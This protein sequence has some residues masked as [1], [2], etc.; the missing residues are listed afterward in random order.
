MGKE[1]E[2][3]EY[4]GGLYLALDVDSAEG[5]FLERREELELIRF[6][7]EEHDVTIPLLKHL[8]SDSINDKLCCMLVTLETE[9][10]RDETESHIWFVPVKL[11][12]QSRHKT[13]SGTWG[14]VHLRF[15]DVAES[16]ESLTVDKHVHEVA[17]HV[18]RVQVELEEAVIVAQ[19]QGGPNVQGVLDGPFLLFCCG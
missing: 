6:G 13:V 15:T 3:Q 4:W 18:G 12:S 2:D 5:G 14:G 16:S 9:L 8:C 7:C 19:R 10:L 11:V 17:A 1:R